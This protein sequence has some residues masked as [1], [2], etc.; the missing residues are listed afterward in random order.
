MDHHQTSTKNFGFLIYPVFENTIYCWSWKCKPSSTKYQYTRNIKSSGFGRLLFQGSTHYGSKVGQ[1]SKKLF[2]KISFSLLSFLISHFVFFCVC[3][4]KFI[5]HSVY[6]KCIWKTM[7]ILRISWM[8]F[9]RNQVIFL[10]KVVSPP[11]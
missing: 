1:I 11:H 4:L 7:G 10:E 5:V 3:A 8:F 2:F 6:K 9:Q